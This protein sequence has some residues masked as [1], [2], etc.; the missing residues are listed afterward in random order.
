[1]GAP[2]PRFKDEAPWFEAAPALPVT[3]FIA[4]I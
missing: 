4:L 1:M 3:L 2:V